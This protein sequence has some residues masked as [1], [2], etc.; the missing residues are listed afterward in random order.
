MSDSTANDA[1]TLTPVEGFKEAS[2]YLSGPIPTELVNGE[3][4]FTGEAMQLLK[5]HGT[6][7][8]DDRDRR[9][10]AKAAQVPGGKYYSMM[11]RSVLPGGLLSSA[12]LMAQLDLCDEVGN[13][14]LRFTTRQAIQVHGILKTDLRKYINR[15]V[16]IGQTTLAACGDVCRNVMCSPLPVQS[17]VY[18]DMQDLAARL[19][20]HFKPRTG[21]YYEL[22]VTDIETGEKTLAAGGE[23]TKTSG[24]KDADPVEP[25][26]G[27]TYLPRKFKLGVALPEDNNADIYSQDIGFLAITDG[28]GAERRIVGYNLIAGGGFGRTPS[29]AKTF[30]AVGQPFCYCPVGEEV[31]AAEAIMK[32]QRDF[33][34]RT[35]RKT[36]RLK[37]LV[38]NWG[39]EKFKAKV[40]EY[41]GRDLAAPKEV[42]IVGHDDA[43][44]WREQGDGRWFYGL[45]I[46]NGRVKDEGSFRLKAA[47]REIC[48]T[49]A[50]PLRVTGHQNLIFCDIEP[51]ARSLLES[52]LKSHGVPLTEDFSLARR[53]SMACPALPTCG[54][55]VTESERAMPGIMD[56]IDAEITKLGLDEEVFTTRMTGCPNGCARPY[57]SDIGLVG[58]A[59]EKYTMFLG[60]SV[61]GHRLNWIYKDMVPADEVA[62]ELGKVFTH[63]KANRSE[64]ESLGDFC[65]RTGKDALLTACGE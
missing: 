1:P 32:V 2:D 7:E 14:T 39:L 29:A 53:W 54:L 19:K 11:V 43:M 23:G 3:P 56:Q 47:L 33:G 26:Y 49:L 41:A 28:V 51:G 6:Y 12:Q 60:G 58:R 17:A 37:Y 45:T 10:E 35:D 40:E 13:G 61:L 63:F 62:A 34:D 65:D 59:K 21:A 55:A 4:N 52:I 8:Q 15:V 30:A 5:H 25:I 27:K 24:I 48:G 42:P 44:G 20:E 64:G 57:N 46:E 50:P 9:K 36:A 38:A 22:W 16:E 18:N 31:S